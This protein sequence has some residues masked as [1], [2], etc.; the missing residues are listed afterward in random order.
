MS[1]SMLKATKSCLKELSQSQ[2][3]ILEVKV[4]LPKVKVT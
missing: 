1:F 2:S 4:D 3:Y